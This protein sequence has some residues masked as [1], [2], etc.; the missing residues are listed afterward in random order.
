M[1]KDAKKQ[2]KQTRVDLLLL[3][4]VLAITATLLVTFPNKQQAVITAAWDF[5]VEMMIILPAVMVL[6][7]LF[8]V[9]VPREIVAKHLGISSGI[10]GVFISIFLGALP[11]GP[12]YV[13]F[14]IA[15]ALVKK[16]MRISNI[17]AFLSAWACIKIPQELVEL[18]FLGL[19]FMSARLILTIIFV[20]F[21]SIAIEKVVEWSEEKA[22]QK[23]KQT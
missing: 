13:A 16:G 15:G 11:T 12:L 7:G 1:K 2:E 23:A 14:P 21:M 20:V 4:A 19:S 9:F 8:M 6:M 3:A 5:F 10:K 17:I 18:Q 22:K